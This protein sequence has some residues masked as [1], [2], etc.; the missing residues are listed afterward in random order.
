MA[1]S[2]QLMQTAYNVRS[3][4]EKVGSDPRTVDGDGKVSIEGSSKSDRWI[5]KLQIS[6]VGMIAIATFFCGGL[7][8]FGVSAVLADIA[9]LLVMAGSVV[10]VVQKLRLRK[11]GSFRSHHNQMRAAINTMHVENTRLT[12]TVDRLE[13]HTGR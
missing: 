5:T 13:Q 8:F 4:V 6:L 7:S 2:L 10:C 1:S 9:S 12:S 3:F 11:L